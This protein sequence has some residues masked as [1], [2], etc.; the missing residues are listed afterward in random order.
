MDKLNRREFLKGAGFIGMGMGMMPIMGLLGLETQAK[1]EAAQEQ[2]LKFFANLNESDELLQAVK[3]EAEVTSDLTMSDGTVIP[4]VYVRLRNRINRIGQGIGSIPRANSYQMIMELWSPEDA[5]NYLKMPLH[6]MFTAANYAVEAGI[7]EKEAADILWDQSKRSLIWRAKRGGQYQYALMPY[8]NGF[9]EFNE[10]DIVFNQSNGGDPCKPDAETNAKVGQFN[11]WGIGGADPNGGDSTF[12]LFR[13][14]PI[15]KDVVA[16]GELLP[17]EDWRAIIMRHNTFTVS[18]CQCR[19]MW[20]GL[21]V[22][23]PEE[24]PMETCLSLG[25]MAEYFI[26]NNIGRQITQEEAIAIVEDVIERGMV[27]EAICAKNP[28]IICCCHS[29]S[30]G[31]LMG[32]SM[33]D[34]TTDKA[35]HYNAYTLEY[36]KEKCLKCGLCVARCPMGAIVQNEDGTLSLKGSCVR[37]GQCVPV[38]PAKA[39]ILVESPDYPELPEDYIDCNRFFAKDRM[40]RGQLID[41]TESTLEV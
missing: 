23:S 20:N 10:L 6:Q 8:I 9:W 36:D 7:S 11:M 37:C 3:N 12:P 25:E 38:C 31:N 27:V 35:K 15:S 19:T 18:P 24:H 17:Y 40:Q 13:A 39:R 30:C 33:S 2:G 28:D 41:F 34:G 26:E 29:K 1:A 5:E 32:H 4:A 22:P 21:G 16:K 14:Y